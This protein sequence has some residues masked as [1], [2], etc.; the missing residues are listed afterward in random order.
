MTYCFQGVATLPSIE[1]SAHIFIGE[2]VPGYV[3]TR[4]YQS[5]G[6]IHIHTLSS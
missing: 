5:H 4:R 2:N 6:A 3:I 1:M